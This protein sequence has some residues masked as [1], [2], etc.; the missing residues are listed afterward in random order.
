MHR[1]IDLPS[2]A[3]VKKVLTLE[4]TKLPSFPQAALK[5]LEV[6]GDENVSM[7][8]V[9]RVIESDPGIAARVLEI[10][11]AARYGLQRKIKTLPEAIVF[12][13]IDEIRKLSMGMTVFHGLFAAIRSRSFDRVHFWR[14][15]V[16]VAVLAMEL[17]KK[18]QCPNPEKAYVAGLLHDVGKVFLDLQGHRDYGEFLH[19]AA[20]SQE[21]IVDQERKALGLGHDDVGAYFCSLWQLPDSIVLPVKY[22]HQR[23]Q[24]KDLSD[25]EALLISIVSLSNFICWTQGIGSFDIGVVCPPILVPEIE[26]YI[27]L[28]QIDIVGRISAMNLEMERVSEFFQFV[29]PTPGQIRENMLWMSFNLS[30]VNTRHVY[31]G[32]SGEAHGLQQASDARPPDL[33]FAL[34]KSLA[35]AKTIKEVIDIVMFHIGTIFEPVHWALLFKDPKNGDMVFTAVGGAN[36]EQLQGLRL[37]KGEGLAGYIMESEAPLLSDDVAKDAR[38]MN[39]VG[40]YS[41]FEVRSCM[42]FML[43]GEKRIFGVI[44][45]VNTINGLP[46]TNEDLDILESIADHASIAIERV[47]YQQ[48]L[49]KM[50]TTDALT[51]L[52]NRYTLE[53]M[54]SNRESLLKECGRDLSIMIIDIDK[55]KRIN[56]LKG[57]KAADELLKQVAGMLRSTFRRSDN[58]F[59]YEGDKFITL[60]P[61]TDKEAADQ[62][63]SRL[64]KS[65][66]V[67]KGELNVSIS[68][69]VHSVQP[70]H[71]RGL[72]QFLEERLARDKAV[73]EGEAGETVGDILHPFL[74]LETESQEPVRKT[75]YRKKVC[76][77]GQFV[78]PQTKTYGYM[79]VEELAL[80]EMRFCMT[81][82]QHSIGPGD[83]LDISFH[84]DDARRSLI[85]R[86]VIVRGVEGEMIDAEFY[87]PPPYAKDLGFYLLA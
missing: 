82:G 12:L 8:D 53:R 57:R 81:S 31:Q 43:M 3:E 14:H 24:S 19:E 85:E 69:F 7:K 71:A 22:H 11:N 47:Y 61:G 86:R 21:T 32:P 37:P 72:I 2:R 48:A 83:Y 4:G 68:I 33:G 9:A 51:G 75:I 23:F 52:K 55:F 76:L 49:Q 40:R 67:L 34:G 66:D 41:G 58:V 65:F 39:R 84:L 46:Y 45:L 44:E 50:A 38:L 26:Q 6:F 28:E 25:E 60:L 54:L 59:R 15:S 73:P 18:I 80:T 30:R 77:D 5:L 29:F 17:A 78:Q 56:E 13:G 35:K 62:A 10:V 1:A 27:D 36:K 87:N 42:G 74:G 64:L 20:T 79:R 70:D 63:R 16:S